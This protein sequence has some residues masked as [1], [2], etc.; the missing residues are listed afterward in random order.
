MLAPVTTLT[1]DYASMVTGEVLVALGSPLEGGENRSPVNAVS[2]L[3]E[4]APL[5]HR[6]E[7]TLSGA[8]PNRM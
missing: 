4:S 8:F 5:D 6:P 2:A 7:L 3:H 1:F